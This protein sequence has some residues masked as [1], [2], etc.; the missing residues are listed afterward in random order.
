MIFWDA[1][2][3]ARIAEAQRTGAF[4][5][6]PGVGRPLDL[7]DDRLVPEEV[8]MAYRILRNA[9]FV[10]PEVEARREAADLR[11]RLT[12]AT[13]EPEKRRALARLALV[14]ACLEARGGALPRA[15][16]YHARLVARF[17]RAR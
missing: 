17:D 1:L 7:D 9:G 16:G 3:E 4:D 13:A 8:R 14:E 2:V 6:L 15:S 12:A 10:P 5:G 11:R